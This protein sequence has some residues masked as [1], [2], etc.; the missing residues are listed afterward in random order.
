MHVTV[1]INHDIVNNKEGILCF[2]PKFIFDLQNLHLFFVVVV[3]GKRFRFCLCVCAVTALGDLRAP[4]YI[5]I[6]DDVQ[7]SNHSLAIYNLK[8]ELYANSQSFTITSRI[9]A[10][11]MNII[12]CY[13][14]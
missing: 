3:N 8:Y 4:R 2:E 5:I 14:S 1:H 6:Y 12:T 7:F 13:F 11:P 10:L 9:P